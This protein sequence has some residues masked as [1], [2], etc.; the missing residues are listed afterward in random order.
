MSPLLDV[1]D[2]TVAFGPVRAVRGVSFAMGRGE[3]LAVVGESGSGKSALAM[4]LTAL[5]RGPG[6]R[7]GGSVQLEGTDLLALPERA[8]RRVRGARV[9]MIFQDALSA[10]NPCETIGAQIVEAIRLH[11]RAG[12]RAARDRAA[13]LLAEVG[14]P[15]PEARL[16]LYPHEFS[17]GQRQRAMIAMALAC[18]PDLLIADEPTTA[19]DVTVQAQILSLLGT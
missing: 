8:L 7:I 10:L 5:N 2:L 1:Q 11:E 15:D 18:G 13:R 12:R 6:V 16:D 14:L 17:G 3:V 9:A 19:L 4:A